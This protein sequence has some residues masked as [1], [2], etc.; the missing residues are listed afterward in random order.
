M[1]SIVWTPVAC[2][3]LDDGCV[4]LVDGVCGHDAVLNALLYDL[5]PYC[6]G[7]LSIFSTLV[8]VLHAIPVVCA[9]KILDVTDIPHQHAVVV[10][11][12]CVFVSA[13]CIVKIYVAG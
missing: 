9:G 7:L 1:L 10:D 12:G 4:E 8:D 3:S 13:V 2:F 6:V 11:V 5:V